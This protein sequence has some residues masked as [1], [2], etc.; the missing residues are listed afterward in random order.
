MFHS[1]T[2]ADQT[3]FL[4]KRAPSKT[5]ARSSKAVNSAIRSGAGVS[6][7]SK[8]GGAGNTQKKGDRNMKALDDDSENLKVKRVDKSI[9]KWMALGR[10]NYQ[11]KSL[12]QKELA[13]KM[14]EKPHVVQEY[15][16]GKAVPNSQVLNKIQR[17]LKIHIS[18]KLAGEPWPKKK[19]QKK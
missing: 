6:T 10:K 16:N 13:Q 8:Y 7:E 12:T 18:G 5:Q 9:G 3:T 19:E 14:N 2:T 11:P 4:S 1:N 17:V 15:E